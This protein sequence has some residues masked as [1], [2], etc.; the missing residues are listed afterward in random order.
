L[1][2]ADSNLPHMHFAPPLGVTPFDF[3]QGLCHHKTRLPRYCVYGL[4]Y[5]IL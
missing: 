3:H 5:I 4:V 2:I 1:K